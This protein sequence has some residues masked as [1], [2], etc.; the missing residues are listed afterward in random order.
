MFDFAAVMSKIQTARGRP[1]LLK[2]HIFTDIESTP[3]MKDMDFC[4]HQ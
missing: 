3:V 4:S 2:K 1:S